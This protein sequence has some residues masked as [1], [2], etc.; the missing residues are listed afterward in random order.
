MRNK[1]FITFRIDPTHRVAVERLA[2]GAGISLSAQ[3]E[4]L[5]T[6]GLE[7]HARLSAEQ[8]DI[9]PARALIAETFPGVAHLLQVPET[10][11][12]SR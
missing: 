10:A 12:R 7:T 3:V 4:R 1:A 9:E 8:G 5:I 6:L 11:R 2:E